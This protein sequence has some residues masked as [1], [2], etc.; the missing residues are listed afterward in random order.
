M[1]SVP[2][3]GILCLENVAFQ[4]Q[5][6]GKGLS[7]DVHML[8]VYLHGWAF[9]IPRVLLCYLTYVYFLVQVLALELHILQIYLDL[10]S[11][12]ITRYS[13]EMFTP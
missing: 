8:R 6:S 3:L 2:I 5:R 9:N 10:D 7:A 11:K 12:E 1:K 4:N 13:E